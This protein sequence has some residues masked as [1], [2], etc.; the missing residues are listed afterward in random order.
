MKGKNGKRIVSL[1][2]MLLLLVTA[3]TVAMAGDSF[4][5]GIYKGFASDNPPQG[6]DKKTYKFQIIGPGGPYTYSTSPENT[7]ETAI[8]K[9]DAGTYKIEETTTSVDGYECNPAYNI[10]M[11]FEAPIVDGQYEFKIPTEIRANISKLGENFDWVQKRGTITITLK[12]SDLEPEPEPEPEPDPDPDPDPSPD[13]DPDPDPSPDSEPAPDSEP[14]TTDP[15]SNAEIDANTDISDNPVPLSDDSPETVSF[16]LTYEGSEFIIPNGDVVTRLKIDVTNDFTPIP[17]EPSNVEYTPKV[18]KTVTQYGETITDNTTFTFELTA[19]EDYGDVVSI[20]SST[21]TV[22]GIGEAQPIGTITFKETENE[23]ET[24]TFTITEKPGEGNN[25][26]TYNPDGVKWELTVTV[27]KDPENEGKLK[28]TGKYKK[29]GEDE[30]S[31]N[32]FAEFTNVLSECKFTPEVEKILLD[33]D[34]KEQSSFGGSKFTFRMEPANVKLPSEMFYVEDKPNETGRDIDLEYTVDEPGRQS[35]D[36]AIIFPKDTIEGDYIFWL[37]ETDENRV[38]GIRYDDTVYELTV[39]VEKESGGKL[40]AELASWQAGRLTENRQKFEATG[41]LYK[42]DTLFA[43]ENRV[44]FT[45]QYTD[46]VPCTYTPQVEKILFAPDGETKLDNSTEEFSFTLTYDGDSE[47]V[48]LGETTAT[49]SAAKPGK[50]GAIT[51]EE[52]GTY[53]FTIREEKKAGYLCDETEIKLTVTVKDL[54]VTK[55]EYTGAKKDAAVFTNTQTEEETGSLIIKKVVSGGPESARDKTF[56]FTVTGPDNY[57][58]TVTLTA[59]ETKTLSGLPLG[60]Y[61]VTESGAEL[62]GYTLTVDGTGP[63]EVTAGETA[64]VTVT[65]TYKPEEPEE[66]EEPTEPETPDEPERPQLPDPNDPDSP[67]TVTITEDDVPTTYV[68]VWDPETE[69]FMYIPEDEVPLFGFETPETG[70]NSQTVLLGGVCALALAGIVALAVTK[71]RNK[72]EQ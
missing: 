69:E 53:E 27:E 43:E 6:T 32:E 26:Y 22:S 50:F 58:E 1:V 18:K 45:N 16:T 20:S 59:G 61:T 52:D 60:T 5:G 9:L 25:G 70:D 4:V 33:K 19:K 21:G 40:T 38:D 54:K 8:E 37:W 15:T 65:N 13:P 11:I 24:Y 46:D 44:K 71:R 67:E 30:P 48:T 23:S 63:V 41:D 72:K 10:E 57:S 7:Y 56:T 51:F 3:G 39:K 29:I 17:P 68:K 66:P 28:A 35:F 64:E 62:G 14:Q 49:A 2:V 34:D 36:K 42:P 55:A 47:K 12:N 31:E